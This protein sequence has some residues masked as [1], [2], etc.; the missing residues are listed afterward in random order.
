[1]MTIWEILWHEIADSALLLD[2]AGFVGVCLIIWA[3]FTE[4]EEKNERRKENDQKN[5]T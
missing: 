3:V 4:N 5:R 2:T 1:M